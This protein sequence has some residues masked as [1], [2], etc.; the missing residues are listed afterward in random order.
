MTLGSISIVYCDST[1]IVCIMIMWFCFYGTVVFYPSYCECIY[2]QNDLFYVEL[3]VNPYPLSV[4][5]RFWVTLDAEFIRKA[6]ST[7]HTGTV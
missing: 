7:V 2:F 1:R 3:D 6:S 4:S 5:F